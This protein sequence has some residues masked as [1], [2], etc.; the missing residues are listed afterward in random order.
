[1]T[2]I[3]ELSERKVGVGPFVGSLQEIVCCMG[4]PV[5]GNPTQFMMEK[6][7]QAAGLDWRYLTL[8]VEAE[9][10]EAAIGG[11]R[12]MKFRGANFTIPHKV[13]VIP[14][15]DRL[16]EPAQLMGAVNCVTREG[17]DL[18]GDN[19]DGRGFLESL[20]ETLDPHGKKV[21]IFGAGG[22]ARAISVELG[23]ASVSEI[24]IANRGVERGQELV[25]LL[26]NEVKIPAKLVVLRDDYSIEPGT[27]LVVNATSIGLGDASARVPLD[28]NS[29]THDV[30]VADVIFNPA[31]TR[32]IRDVEAKGCKIIDGLGMLVNQA[33]IS[34]KNWTGVTP[35]ATIMRDALEEFLSI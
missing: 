23:L 5:R 13:A 24:T 6:A 16:T 9:Q 20:R 17:K 10:L 8:E 27:D 15:L 29:L 34:F 11:M 30:V 3:S 33:V 31:R 22:A 4:N 28:V 21:V 7:F 12:A 26:V 35:D 18:V 1:M 19:T 25:D 2:S 32:L 14:F